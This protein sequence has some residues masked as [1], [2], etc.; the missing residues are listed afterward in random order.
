MAE[1]R[2]PRALAYHH[3]YLLQSRV[4]A[5]ESAHAIP[6]CGVVC[7]VFVDGLDSSVGCLAGAPTSLG[8]G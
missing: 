8:L 5:L 3:I 6:L 2:L 1:H 7:G 4:A